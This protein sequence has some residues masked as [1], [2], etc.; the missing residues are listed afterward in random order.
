MATPYQSHKDRTVGNL[1]NRRHIIYTILETCF[2]RLGW[3][4][5]YLFQIWGVISTVGVC[6]N[7]GE[8]KMI[9]WFSKFHP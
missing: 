3:L 4:Y 8:C 2:Y 6:W 5:V 1:E 9:D 7:L